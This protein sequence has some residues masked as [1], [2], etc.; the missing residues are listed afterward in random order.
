MV[1]N[2]VYIHYQN[3]RKKINGLNPLPHI[4]ISDIEH[5]SIKLVG[6]Y[7]E[8]NGLAGKRK[9][10]KLKLFIY[11]KEV[12]IVDVDS[13]G[14]IKLAEVKNIIR[15]NTI[16]VSIMLANNET[17]VIQPVEKLSAIIKAL[18]G[19]QVP[20][21]VHTDAAQ[22]IGKIKVDVEKLMV[23][24]LTIVGHKFYGPKIGALYARN[25]LTENSS[26]SP[27]YHL[28]QGAG[29]E[30]GL[31]PGTENTPMIVGLGKASQLV[32]KNLDKFSNHMK[33]MRDYLEKKLTVN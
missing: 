15:S 32:I 20:I 27:L 2:S 5:D 4:I 3:L 30:N 24:Y 8:K 23:D 7:Y 14:V 17:G 21:F 28:F 9:N 33:E 10:S 29:Q 6:E 12:S 16:L 19:R 1:F 31:R 13:N 22:A 25:C 11:L 18:D 26:R